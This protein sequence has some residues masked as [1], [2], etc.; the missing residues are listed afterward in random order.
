MGNEN[1]NGQE[2][3]CPACGRYK[4]K[5]IVELSPAYMWDC[6]NCGREN[7]QRAITVAMTDEDRLEMEVGEEGGYWQSYPDTVI[8]KHCDMKYDTRH[9]NTIETMGGG[10]DDP[11]EDD[12]S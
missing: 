11:N 5:E 2:D 6:P 3:K 7:F 9:I 12:Q 10:G 1:G 4:V 8:C